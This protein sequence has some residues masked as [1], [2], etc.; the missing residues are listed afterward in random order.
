ML[1]LGMTRRKKPIE[2]SYGTKCERS[3]YSL[4]VMWQST[5]YLLSIF[6]FTFLHFLEL[7]WM[8]KVMGVRCF[9][10]DDIRAAFEYTHRYIQV[11][12]IFPWQYANRNQ[13]TQGNWN[14]PLLYGLGHFVWNPERKEVYVAYTLQSTKGYHFSMSAHHNALWLGNHHNFIHD[15]VLVTMPTTG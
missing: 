8:I 3:V 7:G 13:T 14:I 15:G 12:C 9:E 11:P 2:L 1:K 6:S 10:R 5:I 4:H